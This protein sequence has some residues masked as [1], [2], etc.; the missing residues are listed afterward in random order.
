MNTTLRRLLGVLMFAGL[1]LVLPGAAPAGAACEGD[2][3]PV[4]PNS[5]P[6]GLSTS[7]PKNPPKGDPLKDK[8]VSWLDTY[9]PSTKW[10]T[11]DLGCG[12]DL[13]NNPTSKPLT[14]QA[15]YFTDWALLPVIVGDAMEDWVSDDPFDFLD[16]TVAEIQ[17]KMRFQVVGLLLPLSIAGLG[18]WLIYRARKAEFHETADAAVGAL[19]IVGVAMFLLQ[20]PQ[21]A[22]DTFQEVVD[23]GVQIAQA[24][25]GA[26]T[27]FS[28]VMFREVVYT[29]W[30]A[31]ELGDADSTVAKK[32]GPDLYRAQHLTYA[33]VAE[34]EA[35]EKARL[36]A[37]EDDECVGFE[38]QDPGVEDGAP[39]EQTCAFGACHTAMDD[40]VKAHQ[41]DFKDV[42]GKV[43]DE[44][45]SAYAVLTGKDGADSR[46]GVASLMGVY[47]WVTSFFYILAQFM[48]GLSLLL[49]RVFIICF[50][51]VA[52]LAVFPQYR[53]KA[54]S[55]IDLLA[56]AFMGG[57]K[58]ILASG[59][60]STVATGILGAPTSL[61]VKLILL[62]ITGVAA[63]MIVKPVRTLKTMVP[64]A[65]P[66][67]SYGAR[68]LKGAVD[69]AF[70]KQAVE[71]GTA[72][73]QLAA[74][75]P[76]AKHRGTS[77]RAEQETLPPLPPAYAPS[78]P[79][80][81]PTRIFA[82]QIH[83][84]QPPVREIETMAVAV[85]ARRQPAALAAGGS[86][87]TILVED[88]VVSR[89]HTTIAVPRSLADHQIFRTSGA[90]DEN[91]IPEPV[92]AAPIVDDR[93]NEFYPI[94]RTRDDRSRVGV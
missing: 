50:P 47:L 82:E 56:A 42:A 13:L 1:L 63:I 68:M 58:F 46:P 62:L 81:P 32:Y 86:S 38:C 64:G 80:R 35:K 88:Q 21:R 78:A 24:P 31:G 67:H 76:S 72:A 52:L 19:L 60:Y 25:F 84:E 16:S 34:A 77:Y 36:E 51:I 9:G 5:G 94:Y 49:I 44:D 91:R 70:T 3:T 26:E 14:A 7:P 54:R 66:Y 92:P 39:D 57:L 85:G 20:Y 61:M 17:E 18:I 30:L 11:Y 40:L 59:I 6:L 37:L 93:G 15:N 69:F 48:L 41:K 22:N 23:G 27:D 4:S 74:P 2:I 12:P 83:P 55:L 90:W 53:E 10:N 71:Q 79:Q 43:E 29:H 73:G 89:P 65:D 45:E 8:D 33:E 87:N 28:D 75:A